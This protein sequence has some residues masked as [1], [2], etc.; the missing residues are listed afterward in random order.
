MTSDCRNMFKSVCNADRRCVI[1]GCWL[2][3]PP[4]RSDW[5]AGTLPPGPHSLLSQCTR[6]GHTPRA[7][8]PADTQHQLQI[9]RNGDGIT[10][11]VEHVHWVTFLTNRYHQTSPVDS[12]RYIKTSVLYNKLREKKTHLEKT[13]FKDRGE[14]RL[15]GTLFDWEKVSQLT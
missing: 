15:I 6:V 3:L 9:T 13:A 2:R 10:L 4:G 7:S 1:W 14:F 11:E 5:P 8:K 12:S